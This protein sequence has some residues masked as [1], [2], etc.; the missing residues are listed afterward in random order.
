MSVFNKESIKEDGTDTIIG[1][2]VKVEGNFVSNGNIIIEGE[3]KGSIKSKKN[4]KVG[5]QAKIE[6][7]I[8]VN[9]ALISGEVRGNIKVKE[10]LQLTKSAKIF[11]DL[12][13][14]ILS[15]AEGALIN[16]KCNMSNVEEK[17]S[18]KE[19]SPKSSAGK[20]AKSR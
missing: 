18:E 17:N 13:T 8:N 2:S 15:V 19:E 11:G 6:A 12:D 9:N 7:N 3:V 20:A 1:P 4:L 5:E 10:K 16:G 14:K